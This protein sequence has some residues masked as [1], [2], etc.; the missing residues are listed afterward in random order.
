MFIGMTGKSL[1]LHTSPENLFPTSQVRFA[2]A[3]GIVGFRVLSWGP[4]LFSIN[5]IAKH[6]GFCFVKQEF[7]CPVF[8]VTRF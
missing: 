6:H 8:C 2:L 7:L 4:A 3:C 5:F 1:A